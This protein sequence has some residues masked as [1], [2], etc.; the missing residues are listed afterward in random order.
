MVLISFGMVG[1]LLEL[2]LK[3][4]SEDVSNE[5]LRLFKSLESSEAKKVLSIFPQPIAE[6]F[7]FKDNNQ[8][9]EHFYREWNKP[10]LLWT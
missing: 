10:T 5:A 7:D 1:L 3:N 4:V 8:L 2:I 6:L 9:L